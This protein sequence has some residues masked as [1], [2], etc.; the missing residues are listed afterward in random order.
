[1][2]R[3]ITLSRRWLIYFGKTLPFFLCLIVF[4]CYAETLFNLAVSRFV[5][6]GGVVIPNN[7]ITFFIASYFEYDWLSVIILAIISVAIETCY[8]NKLA[9]L[10]LGLQLIEKSVI[11]EHEFTTTG[12]C[13]ISAINILICAYLC[14]KGVMIYARKC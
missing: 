4:I 1:M 12:A 10:Y 7:T 13:I 14:M 5:D 9:V 11:Y 8:W 2:N 6:H 3:L